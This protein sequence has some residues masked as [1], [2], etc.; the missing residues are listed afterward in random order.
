MT[1]E[2]LCYAS[3]IIHIYIICDK[4]HL[5]CLKSIMRHAVNESSLLVLWTCL[6]A[7]AAAWE[8]KMWARVFL[9]YFLLF[10]LLQK[11]SHFFLLHLHRVSNIH[12]LNEYCRF[13][14]EMNAELYELIISCFLFLPFPCSSSSSDRQINYLYIGR[15]K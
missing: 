13:A 12:K 6:T 11:I 8:R 10:F 15:Q 3:T 7:A 14:L 4:N 5:L 9:D 2:C 1:W